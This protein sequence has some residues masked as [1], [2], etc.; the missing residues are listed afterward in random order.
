MKKHNE[1]PMEVVDLDSPQPSGQEVDYS[2]F[3]Q[4]DVNENFFEKQKRNKKIKS[5]IE[6]VAFILV[7]SYLFILLIGIFTTQH[8]VDENNQVQLIVADIDAIKDRSDFNEIK[9][10]MEEVRSI[11]VDV[12]ILDIKVA[13]EDITYT[14]AAGQYTALLDDIDVLIPK[15]QAMD[16]ESNNLLIQQSIESILSNDI[17]IYLQNISSALTTS[18]S[19]TLST[20]LQW[21]ES[22]W[23]SYDDLDY[24]IGILAS[25]L[26]KEDDEYFAWDLETAVTEKDPTAILKN[27]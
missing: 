6:I 20:A 5:V 24:Q 15:V 23:Q 9:D 1:I 18:D 10:M 27:E 3:Y 4:E 21:R 7:T 22:I 12:T 16:L 19:S 2:A 26:H 13:N 17:A 25:N 14:E 8:Y 11:L